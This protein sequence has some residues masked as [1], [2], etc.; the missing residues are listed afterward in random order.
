[1]TTSRTQLDPKDPA[2]IVDVAMDFA[3]LASSVNT[4]TVTITRVAGA[5]DASANTML[6]GSPSVSGSTVR[7]RLTGGVDGAEYLIRFQVNAS[8][9]QRFVAPA[10]ISVRSAA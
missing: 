3:A 10:R 7:Q 1:M 6:N 4:P 5:P 8:D 2:E 9:G